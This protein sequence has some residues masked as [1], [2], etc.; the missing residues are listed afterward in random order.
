MGSKMTGSYPSVVHRREDWANTRRCQLLRSWGF[1][2]TVSETWASCLAWDSR[3]CW[4]SPLSYH[5]TCPV[6]DLDLLIFACYP[7]QLCHLKQCIELHPQNLHT[8]LVFLVEIHCWYSLLE[9]ACTLDSF[10]SSV[11]PMYHSGAAVLSEWAQRNA[12]ASD[13]DQQMNSSNA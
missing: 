11:W 6:L 5:W 13:H 10:G 2:D 3:S 9:A 12:R 8:T 4:T 7:T 1:Y